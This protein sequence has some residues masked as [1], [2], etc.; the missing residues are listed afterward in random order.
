M[1]LALAVALFLAV[2][3]GACISSPSF[4]AIYQCTQDGKTVYQDRPCDGT[5]KPIVVQPANG[6]IRAAP[7]TDYV[8]E[9]RLADERQ[10]ARE[11]ELDRDQRERQAFALHCRGLREEAQ[12]ES[13]WRLAI[14][15]AVRASAA[16]KIGQLWQQFRDE[17]C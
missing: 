17:G 9:G 7:P 6:S 5:A 8:I 11:R 14:S 2:L 3:I 12:R 4:A 10:R 16:I 15:P 1:K 13:A